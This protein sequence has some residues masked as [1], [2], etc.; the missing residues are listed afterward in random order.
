MREVHKNKGLNG[1]DY[2]NDKFPYHIGSEVL[3][4]SRAEIETP[5][6][7]PSVLLNNI[8]DI[9]RASGGVADRL[10]N[11]LTF[12]AGSGRTLV[13][14]RDIHTLTI[15]KHE[16][17]YV[18]LIR[19]ELSE[20]EMEPRGLV[21]MNTLASLGALVLKGDSERVSIVSRLSMFREDNEAGN[22]IY[23]GVWRT[24]LSTSRKT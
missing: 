9:I 16:V 18:V 6:E 11:T 7:S 10:G 12:H 1:Y 19:T 4:A 13:E 21:I 8:A 17:S 15:D 23:G 5:G 2:D 3:D 22:T 24:T 20:M 14:A